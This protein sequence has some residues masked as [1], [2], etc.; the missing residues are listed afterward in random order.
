MKNY[1]GH[2]LVT[3]LKSDWKIDIH[4]L[5]LSL[6]MDVLDSQGSVAAV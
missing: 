6:F 5:V 3:V 4:R 1:T 2:D